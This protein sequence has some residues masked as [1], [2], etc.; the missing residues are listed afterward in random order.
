M[1]LRSLAAALLVLLVV[2]GLPAAAQPPTPNADLTAG[3]NQFAFDLYQT[4]ASTN[5]DNFL[6]SPF[7][8]SQALAMTY[9]GAR[10]NTETQMADV[11]HFTLPQTE[12]HAAFNALTTNLNQRSQ[13]AVDGMSGQRFQLSMVNALWGQ[14]GFAFK[15]DFTAL[16]EQNYGAGI[17]ETDFASDPEAARQTINDWVAEQTQ[18]KI[19]DIVPPDSITADT[20]LV[21]ANAI[22]FLASW[23]SPF[24]E[25]DTQAGPFTLVDGSTVTVPMMQQ[26]ESFAYASGTGYQAIELPY[27]GGDV[28]MVIVLPDAGN[29]ANFEATV[30]AETFA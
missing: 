18:D 8:V 23:L 2:V 25:A 17:R 15:P 26:T 5:A 1:V 14:A 24:N 21:L 28:S 12:L 10:G 11:L 19:K 22:Y 3:N 29:Y 7:S 20:S 13:T 16:L 4:V 27:L 9:A 30:N 6:F